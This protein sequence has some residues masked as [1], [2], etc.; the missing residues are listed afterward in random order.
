MTLLKSGSGYYVLRIA[1]IIGFCAIGFQSCTL[2]IFNAWQS[3][4]SQNASYIDTFNFRFWSFGIVAIGCFVSAAVILIRV[5][6]HM[7]SE[8]RKGELNER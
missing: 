4:F 2:S 6:K 7:N 8:H 3:S 5:I 1:G